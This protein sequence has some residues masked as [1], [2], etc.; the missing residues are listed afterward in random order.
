MSKQDTVLLVTKD[1]KLGFLAYDTLRNEGSSWLS[2]EMK[3]MGDDIR[4]YAVPHLPIEELQ[5]GPRSSFDYSLT[6]L[7]NI[8]LGLETGFRA[9]RD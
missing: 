6:R 8:A 2:I 7:Q 9:A 3:V 5:P 1:R 4:I